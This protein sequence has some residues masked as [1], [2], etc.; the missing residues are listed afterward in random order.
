MANS[1]DIPLKGS[2]T[3]TL[4]KAKEVLENGNGQM[5]GS[6]TSGTFSV[7]AGLGK[8]KGTYEV[9]NNLLKITITNKPIYVSANMIE[10]M[11]KKHIS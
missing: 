10:E 1:F 7:P 9:G 6:D 5:T 2:A 4:A 8:V 11:L 3:E